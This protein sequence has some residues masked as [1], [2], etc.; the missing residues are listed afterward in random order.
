MDYEYVDMGS[1]HLHVIKTKKFKTVTVEVNFRRKVIKEE[2][3]VRN[4]LK[5]VL[6]STNQNFKTERDLIKETENLYDLKL[7]SSNVRIGAY[8]NLSFKV[9]FLNEKYT[10]PSM[11]EYSVAFLMD[12]LFHPD[13]AG[14]QFQ[15]EEV[16]K[17]KKK[18]EKS[19]R[20]LKD[21]KLK[22]TL[23]QLLATTDHMPYSYNYY[24]D[25]DDLEHIT[26]AS[27]YE[28]YLSVLNEDYVDVFVVGDVD[29]VK[30]KSIL[31]KYFKI[32]TFKKEKNDLLIPEM[33]PRKR[34]KKMK[35]LDVAN[36]SQLTAFCTLNHLTDFERK[37]V[38]LVYN[39]MLGGSSNSLLFDTVREKNSY[40]YY[41]NS[42]A[43][44]YDNLLLIYAG[45]ESGNSENVL[46]LVKK[47]LNRI[48]KGDF[49]DDILNNSKETLISSVQASMDSPT[50]IINTYYAKALVQSDDFDERM[51][52]IQQVTREDVINFSKKVTLHTVYL[53]E[54]CSEEEK[55]EK[56]SIK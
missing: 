14:H 5:S 20:K 13:I 34:I 15:S 2:I 35:E 52:K 50:G 36:Q 6:L 4:L 51:K 8:S 53:L 49:D 37:Y 9:R 40:A 33:S 42:N 44:A 39:E 3:T 10:E 25:I 27:L 43:K 38:L 28:Y 11:N 1:Y 12:I 7:V 31:K 19:I 26:P 18:L 23:F 45:I 30:V 55:N 47:T 48:N 56:V 17:N 21:S 24:G 54:G 41:V 16:I 22:Y 29:T 46:K 32:T